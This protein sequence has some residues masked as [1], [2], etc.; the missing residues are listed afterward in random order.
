LASESI[1]LEHAIEIAGYLSRH[2]RRLG[3]YRLSEKY[4]RKSLLLC[5]ER[6]PRGSAEIARSQ[7]NLALVLRDL[8]ELEEARDLAYQAYDALL[9]RL[10]PGH[11]YTKT[12]KANWESI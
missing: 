9:N 4:G 8:G 6:Y 11:S 2:Y 1:E 5:E 3:T 7:S 10:G 12:A